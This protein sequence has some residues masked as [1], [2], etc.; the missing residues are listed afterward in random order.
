MTLLEFFE[1]PPT[2]MV[3]R[4]D[5]QLSLD[6]L[7]GATT[8]QSLVCFHTLE[9]ARTFL[10]AG[11]VPSGFRP[12]Q[13]TF[14]E[15]LEAITA[16]ASKGRTHLSVFQVHDDTVSKSTMLIQELVELVNTLLVAADALQDVVEGTPE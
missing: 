7:P 14:D 4:P 8:P 6:C 2:V 15:W 1:N 12:V 11:S 9:E 13:M 16:E 10:S 3:V 5:G